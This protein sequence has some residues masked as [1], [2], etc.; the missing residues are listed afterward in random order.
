ML[1]PSAAVYSL[2]KYLYQATQYIAH[3][4]ITDMPS[5]E[6]CNVD[7]ELPLLY[8]RTIKN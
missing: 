8:T 5:S 6:T 1:T 3:M 2:S 7:L 4:I